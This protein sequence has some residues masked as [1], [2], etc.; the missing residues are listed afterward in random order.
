MK[1][2]YYRPYETKQESEA[3]ARQNPHTLL[4]L[5]MHEDMRKLALY[6]GKRYRTQG[7]MDEAL[8]LSAN[9]FSLG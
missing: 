3:M 1:D 4:F 2:V 7:M 8:E 5:L 6:H 9:G